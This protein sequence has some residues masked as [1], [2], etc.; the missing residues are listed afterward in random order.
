MG[1]WTSHNCNCRALPGVAGVKSVHRNIAGFF[2]SAVF[3]CVAAAADNLVENPS[4]EQGE[5]DPVPGWTSPE[6]I[7]RDASEAFHG[8]RALAASKQYVCSKQSLPNIDVRGRRFELSFVTRADLDTAGMVYVYFRDSD[9]RRLKVRRQLRDIPPYWQEQSFL[10]EPPVEARRLESIYLYRKAE[11]AGSIWFDAF[12]FRELNE[13]AVDGQGK[14]SIEAAIVHTARGIVALAWDGGGLGTRA[15]RFR[16]DMKLHGEAKWQ[17]ITEPDLQRTGLR[18]ANVVARKTGQH[19]FRCVA[20]GESGEAFS[21]SAE[22]AVA[23][24]HAGI[25]RPTS[26]HPYF[27]STLIPAERGFGNTINLLRDQPILLSLNFAGKLERLT[28]PRVV[29]EL[30]AGVELLEPSVPYTYASI[31]EKVDRETTTRNGNA[32]TRYVIHHKIVAL[33]EKPPYRHASS[34]YFLLRAGQTTGTLPAMVWHLEDADRIFAEKSVSINVLPAIHEFPTTRRF[35]VLSY[36]T[37]NASKLTTGAQNLLLDALDRI[38]VTDQVRTSPLARDHGARRLWTRIWSLNAAKGADL[39]PEVYAIDEKGERSTRYVCPYRLVNVTGLLEQAVGDFWLP[40]LTEPGMSEPIDGMI[41]DWEPHG[42]SRLCFCQLCRKDFAR[43]SGIAGTAL[44]PDVILER[45]RDAWARF[46]CWQHAQVIRSWVGMIRKHAPNIEAL[47]TS[48]AVLDDRDLYHHPE[49]GEEGEYWKIYH[50]KLSDIRLFDEHVDAH[51]P[52][53]YGAAPKQFDAID[54]SVHAVKKPLIPVVA[55]YYYE[56]GAAFPAR[57]YPPKD[58]ALNMLS[59]ATAGAAGCGIYWGSAVLS[60]GTYASEV[61][62]AVAVIAR[63]ED[64]L[65]DG[66]RCDG[67]ATVTGLPQRTETVEIDGEAR[68][69]G[70]PDWEGLLRVRCFYHSASET[71][72]VA[73]F[74]FSPDLEAFVKVSI[75]F[76]P[77][78]TYTVYD[79]STQTALL[80]GADRPGFTRAELDNGL[81]TRA[82]AYNATFLVVSPATRSFPVRDR[83]SQT[84]VISLYDEYCKSADGEAAVSADD[85]D[86]SIGWGNADSSNLLDIMVSSSTHKVWIRHQRGGKIIRWAPE[87]GMDNLLSYGQDQAAGSEGGGIDLFWAPATAHWTGEENAPYQIVASEVADSVAA[88]TLRRTLKIGDLAGLTIDKTY[89]I[90]GNE[91]TINVSVIF[92]NNGDRPVPFAYWVHYALSTESTGPQYLVPVAEGLREIVPDQAG[93]KHTFFRRPGA[94][95]TAGKMGKL[96]KDNRRGELAGNWTAAYFPDYNSALTGQF[97]T[98]RVNQVYLYDVGTLRTLEWMYD[99]IAL[100]PGETRTVGYELRHLADIQPGEIAERLQ[101]R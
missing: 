70:V 19:L 69:V 71:H 4:F 92:T 63:V 91:P 41:V 36:S 72:V 2:L 17:A 57:I 9:D 83:L 94:A 47:V 1:T 23:V 86:L 38:G 31:I 101:R 76:L 3:V 98:S 21:A 37:M 75:P 14:P 99:G 46:R 78:G 81:I 7:I 54:R 59:A 11:S 55:S 29:I 64:L 40:Y 18:M 15:Q 85:G 97:D 58:V 25:A 51:G 95:Y 82:P 13:E 26:E 6:Q 56:G 93:F 68:E 52:M 88:I 42:T 16:V 80:S 61:A 8:G 67:R 96:E 35:R 50:R 27:R 5:T 60:D 77:V 87:N 62:R 100:G 89:R 84:E 90:A 79:A 73:I 22:V 53:M 33:S 49:L 66:K 74:N 43:H 48:A 34:M 65:I 39:A 10:I 24:T 32:Y 44:K 45:H 30:P 12:S 20:L 28:K